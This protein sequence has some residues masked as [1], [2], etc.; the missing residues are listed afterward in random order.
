MVL[1]DWCECPSCHFPAIYSR[2]V[3]LL[4]NTSQCPMCGDTVVPDQVHCSQ[5]VISFC[6]L[7]RLAR[8][9]LTRIPL[10]PLLSYKVR[11]LDDPRPR[12][13]N[14]FEHGT[15]RIEEAD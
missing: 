1:D 3:A 12:L 6:L 8:L 4:E 14:Y 15:F 2:F 7:H 13:L 5:S 11:R 9:D 10:H